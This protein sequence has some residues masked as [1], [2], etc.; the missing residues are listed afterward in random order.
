MAL[1]EQILMRTLSIQKYFSHN[2]ARLYLLFFTLFLII[3]AST[4][5]YAAEKEIVNRELKIKIAMIYNFS[6]FVSWPDEAFS[7][8]NNDFI[9]CVKAKP[10]IFDTFKNSLKEKVVRGKLVVV[11]PIEINSSD[12]SKCHMSYI[13]SE[14]T[15]N[16]NEVLSRYNESPVLTVG[17][18]DG[19]VRQGGMIKLFVKNN[20]LQFE[21]NLKKSEREGLKISSKLLNIASRVSR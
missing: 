21:I 19:F 7:L 15:K 12:Q 8:N 17:D 4:G 18:S 3:L 5:L 1:L 2:I 11:Q 13:S 14:S 20:R 10:Y 16:Q 6:K 9:L